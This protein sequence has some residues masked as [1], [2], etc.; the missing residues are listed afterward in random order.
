MVV[1]VA[2][3]VTFDTDNVNDY[4]SYQLSYLGIEVE[5]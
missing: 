3:D 4:P 1:F 2:F 5:I